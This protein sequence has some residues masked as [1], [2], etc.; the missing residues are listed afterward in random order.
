M[1]I[2]PHWAEYIPSS[3]ADEDR[4]P[5][6][7]TAES[8]YST[9]WTHVSVPAET[10]DAAQEV[11]AES[12]DAPYRDVD[13]PPTEVDDESY[14]DDAEVSPGRVSEYTAM[15]GIPG[16]GVCLLSLLGVGVCAALDLVVAR[17]ITMFFDLCFVTVCLVA[18]MAVRRRDLFTTGVLPPLLYAAV[19]GVVA[20]AS[21]GTFVQFAGA[22]K[23]FMT[24]LAEHA[25]ALVAGY[26]VAL[27]TVGSRV[28]ASRTR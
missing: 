9:V 17:G 25:P 20:V 16:R 11:D 21:P 6:P 15:P 14:V 7:E 2:S 12:D 5:L 13:P 8:A 3:V 26:A 18:S 24:G 10:T 28:S 19:L 1:S 23:A 27:L 4:D 22:S